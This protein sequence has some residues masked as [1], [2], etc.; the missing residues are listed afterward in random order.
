MTTEACA[1]LHKDLFLSPLWAV[2]LLWSW[3][4]SSVNL[5]GGCCHNQ[6]QNML[7]SQSAFIC[8]IKSLYREGWNSL[9]IR[10]S[11]S[12]HQPSPHCKPQQLKHHFQTSVLVIAPGCLPLPTPTPVKLSGSRLLSSRQRQLRPLHQSRPAT[13]LHR[14]LYKL[15]SAFGIQAWLRELGNKESTVV[16]E[17]VDATVFWWSSKSNRGSCRGPPRTARLLVEMG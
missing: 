13:C 6:M 10:P 8:V 2:Y 11:S 16:P 1:H 9:L 7:M 5:G 14:L 12:I 4:P 3:C 15:N 17:L